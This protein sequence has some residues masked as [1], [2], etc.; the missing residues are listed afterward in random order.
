M[1]GWMDRWIDTNNKIKTDTNNKIKI[2]LKIKIKIYNE[3]GTRI[4]SNEHNIILAPQIA[5]LV[6]TS[7]KSLS[8]F[9]RCLS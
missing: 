8:T 3:G 6:E 5:T 4:I 1:D 9:L 7:E 2:K